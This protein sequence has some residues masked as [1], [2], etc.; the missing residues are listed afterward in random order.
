M[1]SNVQPEPVVT[2][3]VMAD[4]LASGRNLLHLIVAVARRLGHRIDWYDGEEGN[5]DPVPA[6]EAAD[7][8][9]RALKMVEPT[10]PPGVPA[11]IEGVPI[12]TRHE[13]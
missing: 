7:R 1:P 2:V 13:R 5:V 8:L 10:A 4:D 11:G 3:T 12:G 9:L 6:R